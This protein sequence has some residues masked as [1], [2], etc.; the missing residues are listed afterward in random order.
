[1]LSARWFEE[2]WPDPATSIFNVAMGC[3]IPGHVP[4][5][6]DDCL[7]PVLTGFPRFCIWNNLYWLVMGSILYHWINWRGLILQGKTT[8][9]DPGPP[10]DRVWH[11]YSW[12]GPICGS[13]AACSPESSKA[14]GVVLL[15][16]ALSVFPCCIYLMELEIGC[17]WPKCIDVGWI[18]HLFVVSIFLD[19]LCVDGMTLRETLPGSGSCYFLAGIL[20]VVSGGGVGVAIG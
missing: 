9:G 7:T 20:G 16:C 3:Q 19:Y 4:L 5:S 10:L 14:S 12:C 13:F 1:M 17:L 8:K 18:D 11:P 6:L 2:G 15:G